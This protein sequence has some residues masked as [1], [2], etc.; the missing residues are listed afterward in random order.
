[1]AK[2]KN[3]NNEGSI[4][5]RKNGTWEGR[6]TIGYDA[7]GRQKQ[8]SVY[9]KTRAEVARKLNEKTA[10]IQNGTYIIPRDHTLLEWLENWLTTYAYI[11]VRAST[12][13]S[14]QAYINNHIAPY[15]GGVK[16]QKLTTEQLQLF[17]NEKAKN[18]RLDGKGGLSP[19][20]IR[21]L[22][23]MLHE[24]LQQAVTNKYLSVN[25]TE[26]VVL[27]SHQTPDIIVF[28]PEEQ[29]AILEACK[30]E[31]LGFAIELD[32][33]TGL[34]IGEICALKWSDFDFAEKIFDVRRTLQR[35]QKKT[36]DIGEKSAKTQI[37]EGDTKTKNGKRVIPITDVM[38]HK[39][40]QHRS[41]QNFE[42]LRLG[43]G[44]ADHGYVFANE[45]GY[46]VEP[47]YLRDVYERILKSAGVSHYKFHTIRHTFATRA[48][49][50]GAPVKIV[51][52]ILGHSSV[53]LTMDVYCHPSV[54]AKRSVME[55]L[56]K[57]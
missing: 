50:N 37:V 3:G 27:P 17:F 49:E 41:R 31:R 16:L 25:V 38:Y 48:I 20:T 56:E 15:I 12:Y 43:K 19:K 44:Y 9:G 23:N 6:Y 45:F 35:I 1:M 28:K 11:K 4:R 7:R 18:G 14:Y 54:S 51:S 57:L 8:L 40:M 39:L 13:A 42:K 2:G 53:Q 30:K 52:E 22:Y 24:A 55:K 10:A 47:S 26:G 5:K 33:M 46:A 34:R 32:F 21:N 29:A 36:S